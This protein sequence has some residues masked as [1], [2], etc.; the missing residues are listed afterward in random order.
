MLAGRYSEG[1][2][3][4]RGN[5]WI[6]YWEERHGWRLP[7]VEKPMSVGPRSSLGGFEGILGSEEIGNDPPG[8]GYFVEA[9]G[10]L[11]RRGLRGVPG[12]G[13]GRATTYPRW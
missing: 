9:P 11:G 3:G 12:R 1:G 10:S 7:K 13:L 6:S 2:S 4:P 5:W 8:S